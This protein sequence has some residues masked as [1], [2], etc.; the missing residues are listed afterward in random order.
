MFL[1]PVDGILE[2][3]LSYGQT[4]SLFVVFAVFEAVIAAKAE[5]AKP[6]LA[7]IGAVFLLAVAL[8]VMF[9]D[10]M[11]FWYMLIPVALCVL[12]FLVTRKNR[13]RNIKKGMKYN[14]DGLLED[15]LKKIERGE[16]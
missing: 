1:F 4:I 8:G 5:T 10:I 15:E 2:V 11:F 13:A 9:D 7:F 16:H 12:S 6:G 14:A 3:I